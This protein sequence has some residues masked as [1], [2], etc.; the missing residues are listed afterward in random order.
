MSISCF[1]SIIPLKK[2]ELMLECRILKLERLNL[3][4]LVSAALNVFVITLR[5][6]ALK[7][8]LHIFLK[9]CLNKTPNLT[10]DK[11]GHHS[12]HTIFPHLL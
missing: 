2:S 4:D 10:K 8:S 12:I 1:L 6:E 5:C 9:N 3:S 7:H 11:L